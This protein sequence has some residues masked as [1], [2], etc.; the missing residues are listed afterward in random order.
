MCRG[1][2]HSPQRHKLHARAKTN[3]PGLPSSSD[4]AEACMFLPRELWVREF[5]KWHSDRLRRQRESAGWASCLPLAQKLAQRGFAVEARRAAEFF[6]DAQELVVLGNAVGAAGGRGL[7]LPRSGSHGKIGDKSV[8]GLPRAVRNDGVVSRFA[9][10][11][12]R[13][14]RFRYRPDLIQLDQ[15]G[16]ADSFL[17]A[18]GES[19]GVG[20]EQVVADELNSLFRR[21]AAGALRQ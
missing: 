15:N 7:D 12:D 8:L 16:V 13:V 21:F 20:D 6:F 17:N 11:L 19:L 14:D 10:H 2:L 1:S 9:G 18:A 3:T 5:P 4:R